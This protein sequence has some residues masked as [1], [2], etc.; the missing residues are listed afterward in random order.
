MAFF[1]FIGPNQMLRATGRI[2]QLELATFDVKHLILLYSRHP[3]VHLHLHYLHIKH[4]HQGVEYLRSLSRQRFAI[5]KL[6]ATL[7]SIQSKC[8]TCRKRKAVTLNSMMVDLP[9]ERLAS[10]YPSFTNTRLDYFGPFYVLV[11]RSTEVA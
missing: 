4:C 7:R 2:Q 5:V 9:K 8:V 11:E 1:P 10:G 6:R 3:L